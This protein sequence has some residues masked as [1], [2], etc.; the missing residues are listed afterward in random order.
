MTTSLQ[1]T[2]SFAVEEK[3]FDRSDFL[4]GGGA[5]IVAAG[6]PAAVWPSGAGATSG[7]PQAWPAEVDPS[8]LDSWLAIH[9]DGTVTAFTGKMENSQ[10]NRTAI[11]QIVAEELDVPVANV[12]VLMGDTARTV[13][14][15]STVG[16]LTIR[17][18]WP[19]APA[20]RSRWAAGATCLGCHAARRS[21]E[22]SHRQERRRQRAQ[23][24]FPARLVRG[25]RRRSPPRRDDPGA[26]Q[27]PWVRARAWRGAAEGSKSS[28][29]SSASRSRASTFR[30]R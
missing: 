8:K 20:G 18:C 11:P 5:L 16:S 12:R 10:G 21:G 22:Q 1:Q 23:R 27:W 14:Q 15:G 4:R 17:P 28:T 29:Q 24:R 30:A 2:A 7:T 6:L 13:D 26:G 3:T 9:A 19:S 25:A